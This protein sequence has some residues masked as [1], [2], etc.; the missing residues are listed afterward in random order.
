[1]TA[2]YTL[3]VVIDCAHPHVLADW[4]AQ[5]LRWDVEP[6]D[7]DF[8]RSM[9]AQGLA[10]EEDTTTHRGALV[11]RSG[12]AITHPAGSQATGGAPRILFQEVPEPKSVKNRVHLD[13][14]AG[15][16]VSDAE[17]ERL[18]E[19]GAQG[20]G[21]GSQGPHHWVVLADP[22]GNEFC[23]PVPAAP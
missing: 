13:L 22:E 18:L 20:V 2:P 7:E 5:A 21:A 1:M 12:V 19:L 4:W 9:I 8:I 6:Q 17:L 16:P 3:Q 15:E 10:T 11:W 14:R 23:L